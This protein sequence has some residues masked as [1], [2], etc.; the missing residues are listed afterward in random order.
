MSVLGTI[1]AIGAIGGATIGAVGAN[2]AAG[3]Q[4]DAAN[5]AAALQHQDAQS[6]LQ[7]QKDQYNT[8]QANFAPWLSAG[9]GG[10][11]NLANLLGVPVSGNLPG[12]TASGGSANPNAT[13]GATSD[14]AR[15][16]SGG[17]RGN[18][19]AGDFGRPTNN[20]RYANENGVPT[21]TRGAATAPQSTSL[22]SLI[23]PSLGAT[24]SLMQPFSEKFTAPTDVTE[25]NDP[26]YKFRLSQG[27][28]ALQNSAAAR[29][30]LLSGGTAKAI[31]DY[32]QNSAS[33]EYGNVYNRSLG[34][35]QQRFNQFQI[36][37]SDKYNRLAALS[38]I[39]Q[40]TAGQ[41]S[42]AGQAASGNISNILLTSG[43]QIGQSLN[44][45]GAARASGYAGVSNALTGG[46]NNLSQLAML[47][48]LYG[49]NGFG[50]QSSILNSD[51]TVPFINP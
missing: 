16:G 41:L 49:G 3:T 21:I 43:G 47:N 44:N 40:T 17:F 51:G 14:F 25:Q 27:L 8:S 10:L 45:A 18:M 50:S 5:N 12:T 26:G 4:A 13:P 42:S 38:G 39:G 20:M 48:K 2:A 37:Q 23:N 32:A 34:E 15:P 9:R 31:N 36:G 11:V 6:A 22:S 33:S 19:L 35:Y 28:E 29:G 24:G 46:I 1:G 7:F 30:N